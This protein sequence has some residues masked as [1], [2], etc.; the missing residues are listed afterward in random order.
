M[1]ESEI[2]H[3][4]WYEKRRRMVVTSGDGRHDRLPA[5]ERVAAL[6]AEA[7]GLVLVPSPPG[8]VRWVRDPE[9]YAL[10]ERFRH[11][12]KPLAK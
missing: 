9:S 4:V 3:L 1:S 11:G 8:L 2:E 12:V 10:S 7:A 5:T 6:I